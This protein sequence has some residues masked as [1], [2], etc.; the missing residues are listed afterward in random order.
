M[1]L[2]LVKKLHKNTVLPTEITL[3][4]IPLIPLADTAVRGN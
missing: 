1:H 3:P 2:I 4:I